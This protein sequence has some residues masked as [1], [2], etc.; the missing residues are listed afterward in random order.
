MWFKK[1]DVNTKA[2]EGVHQQTLLGAVLTI[3]TAVIVL[4]LV[5]SELTSFYK[6]DVVSRMEVDKRASMDAVKLAFDITFP[7]VSC[8]KLS[9]NHEVT[10]GTIH[11]TEEGEI[12]KTPIDTSPSIKGCDVRGMFLLDKV[13]GNFKFNVA[14]A[15]FNDL[16]LSHSIG[17]LNF[18][19]TKGKLLD[20]DLIGVPNHFNRTMTT[21]PK[22]TAYYQYAMQIV[23]TEY[24]TLYGQLSF[25][26]QY[27]T[28]EKA[29]SILQAR[30]GEFA[31]G[32]P[33]KDFVGLMFSYDFSPVRP[34]RHA[35]LLIYFRRL[36]Y[37]DSI[38]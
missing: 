4:C 34:T 26:N 20:G 27:S 35:F 12:I 16:N 1:F 15:N 18:I 17:L 19:P 31:L 11:V 10:K 33:Q 29:V 30:Q 8:D 3:V 9:Y 6:I 25:I 22:D 21:V 13:A 28:N 7:Y 14:G 23:P 37:V 5:F 38:S 24:K 2:L 36:N 32:M